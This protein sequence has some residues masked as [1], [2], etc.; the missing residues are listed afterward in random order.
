MSD[1]AGHAAALPYFGY[2]TLLGQSHM[3]TSYPSAEPLGT[4]TYDGHE[5]GFHRYG[6]QGDGGCTIVPRAGAALYGVL[7]RLDDPDMQ[8]LMDV[9]GAAAHYEAREIDVRLLSGETVRAVT[10]RVDGDEGPWSPPEAYGRLVTD[11]A[12]EARLPEAYQAR[13]RAIVESAQRSFAE[14]PSGS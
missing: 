3:R 9:G 6:T 8:R 7:Y 5:L 13:L 2:G 10:L 1:Q 14:R 12:A 4:G 11:G